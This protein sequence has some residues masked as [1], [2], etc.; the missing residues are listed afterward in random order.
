MKAVTVRNLS[1]ATH[2]A[3]RAR[4]VMNG[5]STEAEIRHILDASVR[6]AIGLGSLLAGIGSE[7]KGIELPAKRD[8]RP[9]KLAHFE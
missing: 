7:L 6:P 1:E 2:R 5:R 9:V 8:A 4:A 3:L